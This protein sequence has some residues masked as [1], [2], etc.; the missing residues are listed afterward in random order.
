MTSWT[1]RLAVDRRR[2]GSIAAQ[3]LRRV[4]GR[5]RSVEALATDYSMAGAGGSEE[6]QEVREGIQLHLSSDNSTGYKG[7]K[8]DRRRNKFVAERSVRGRLKYLGRFDTAIEAA[9]AYARSAM[10]GDAG[11]PGLPPCEPRPQPQ[12]SGPSEPEGAPDT[13]DPPDALFLDGCVIEAAWKHGRRLVGKVQFRAEASKPRTTKY[14]IFFEGRKPSG[15]RVSWN[16]LKT[17][18]FKVIASSR[19]MNS[20]RRWLPAETKAL[21]RRLKAGESQRSVAR[22]FGRTVRSVEARLH[23]I[24]SCPDWVAASAKRMAETAAAQAERAA[25]KTA[26]NTARATAKAARRAEKAAEREA[27]EA[28]T[29]CAPFA[30]QWDVR[31][32]GKRGQCCDLQWLPWRRSAVQAALRRVANPLPGQG[33][34]S[35]VCAEVYRM[36]R[37]EFSEQQ[38]AVSPWQPFPRWYND[39]ARL[40]SDSH[41][42]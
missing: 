22:S 37:S 7:I 24:R 15:V 3:A 31:C 33:T 25:A 5:P 2:P 16:R 9:M 27:K 42:A 18:Q 6:V 39:V 34:L 41:H 19:A 10:S 29:A 38:R 26:R 14:R 4:T 17:Y 32:V 20:R 36:H 35:D 40:L 28:E 11:D 8:L 21:Q 30:E 1:S 23:Q 13:S 12:S